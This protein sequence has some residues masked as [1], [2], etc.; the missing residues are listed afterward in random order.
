[1]FYK[2]LVLL[3]LFKK[4]NICTIADSYTPQRACL[5]HVPET[6]FHETCKCKVANKSGFVSIVKH[7]MIK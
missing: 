6:M 1:M 3:A 2:I 4:K 5:K 7:N